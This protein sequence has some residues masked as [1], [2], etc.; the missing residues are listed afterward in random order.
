MAK[1]TNPTLIQGKKN[2]WFLVVIVL[3]IILLTLYL[4]LRTSYVLIYDKPNYLKFF[5]VLLNRLINPVP[6]VICFHPYSLCFLSI[7]LI[8]WALDLKQRAM[9]KPDAKWQGKEHGSNDFYT[10]AEMDD[11]REKKTDPI[12]P[13]TDEEIKM[14]ED[15]GKEFNK[16]V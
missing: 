12:I 11:F 9:P 15:Y 7:H 8:I 4:I 5:Q 13:F 3:I 2:N 6:F 1:N 14:V 10:K 16:E